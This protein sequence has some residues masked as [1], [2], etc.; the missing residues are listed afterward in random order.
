METRHEVTREPKIR[1]LRRALLLLAPVA[2]MLAGCGEPEIE[3]RWCDRE[4]VVDGDH[5]EWEGA[6]VRV[7]DADAVIGLLND[8]THLYL[9]LASIDQ[10]IKRQVL[11]RGFTLWFDPEGGRDRVLGIRFPLGAGE[12]GQPMEPREGRPDP[13]ALLALIEESEPEIEIIT[14]G[15][16]PTRMFL[17]Q[18]PGFDLDVGLTKGA[19]VYEAKIP[20][21]SSDGNYAI[22]A[23]PGSKIGI[24][25]TTPRMD[26]ERMRGRMSGEGP[27]GGSGGGR[28]G[29]RRGGMGGG[30]GGGMRGGGHTP[31]M[32][33]PL[34]IWAKVKIAS[35]EGGRQEP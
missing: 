28:G 25:L 7:D 12:M 19:L 33:E 24:G 15:D 10:E 8:G 32:P 31:S 22:G 1:H 4:V 29:G 18:V 34:D 17:A 14:G 13:D 27:P 21:L 5:T 11:G 2:F 30:K 23:A 26:R 6:V 16:L 3:S 35:G 9:C 20:L